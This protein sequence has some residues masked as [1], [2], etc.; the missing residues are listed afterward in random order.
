MTAID[1][2]PA[3]LNLLNTPH[4]NQGVE[5]VRELLGKLFTHIDIH[6]LTD[7]QREKLFRD[8]RFTLTQLRQMIQDQEVLDRLLKRG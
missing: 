8:R 3:D 6:A 4:H 1:R 5:E 7:S 2:I